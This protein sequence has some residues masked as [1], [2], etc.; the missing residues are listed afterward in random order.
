MV[1]RRTIWSSKFIT[2]HEFGPQNSYRTGIWLPKLLTG[3]VFVSQ[4]FLADSN[5]AFK[6]HYLFKLNTFDLSLVITH[7]FAADICRTKIG[8]FRR[9]CIYCLLEVN[10]S[11]ICN[12][13]SWILNIIFFLQDNA[14]CHLEKMFFIHHFGSFGSNI[15]MLSNYW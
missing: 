13:F 5:L 14:S 6:Y 8:N 15:F 1:E 4:N 3:Q 10:G 2:G 11:C 9:S 7:F 12:S